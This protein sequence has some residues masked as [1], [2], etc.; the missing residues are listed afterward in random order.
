[1]TTSWTV[2]R[3][4]RDR[5]AWLLLTG[6]VVSGFGTS[7]L[8]LASG[9]WVKDLTGSDGLAALCMLAMWAPTL[10]GPALGTLADRFPRKPLLIT[11]N[12]GLA[13][14]L[15]T[16]FAVDSPGRLWLLFAVLCCYG[17]AGVVE[18]AAQSALV[19]AAVG[20]DLRGDFNGLRMT[21]T[22]GMKLV[23]PLTGAGLYA[24]FGG[25]AVACLDAVTFVLTAALC[26]LL[27]V[28]EERPVR[29]GD[30][31]WRETTEGVRHM[32]GHARLRPLVAAGGTTMLLASLSST[33]LY[34]VVDR[35]GHSPAY[36]GALYAVQGAG[37][38]AVGL[39]SGPALRRLGGRRF[40]AAGIAL[41]AVGVAARAVPSDPV[42]LAAGA[43]CG[44]GLPCVLIAALTA[45]QRETPG[46]LLGRATATANTLMFTPNVIGLAVGAGLVEVAGPGALLPVYGLALLGTAAVL[47][48]QRTADSAS[49][50]SARSRSDANPA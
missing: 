38:V 35:L 8:W 32:W 3:V 5:N 10:V 24:A 41:T 23:A 4:L 45:V 25:P 28:R 46:P 15:L 33:T 9:V 39:V 50:T 47:A 16:L 1:M 34:A 22:E 7:S 48:A 17:A 37:S 6:V 27:R 36:A 11:G 49:R 44:L 13:A 26:A 20:P 30:G 43:A 12:L 42:A 21:A 14:L 18:D 19:T 2:F 31:W 40:A 29:S